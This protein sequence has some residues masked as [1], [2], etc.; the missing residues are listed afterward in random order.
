M[1]L[2]TVIIDRGLVGIDDGTAL[3]V[4]QQ[5]N[6]MGGVKDCLVSF[7]AGTRGPATLL[8]NL[9]FTIIVGKLTT[10][11]VVEQHD[12]E[13]HPQNSNNQDKGNITVELI[14]VAGHIQGHIEMGQGQAHIIIQR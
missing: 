11:A 12:H 3:R 5:H 1:T 13:E 10:I 6:R 9:L 2:I 7:M 14:L 4:H 8:A